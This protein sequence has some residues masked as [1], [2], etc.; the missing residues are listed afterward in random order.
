MSTEEDK[1]G[2]Y[3]LPLRLREMVMVSTHRVI[4]GLNWDSTLK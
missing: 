2:G 1:S 3:F 4:V